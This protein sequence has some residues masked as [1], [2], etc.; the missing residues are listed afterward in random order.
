MVDVLIVGC[1]IVGASVAY[2][3]AKD[4]NLRVMLVDKENDV[5]TGTTRANSAILHAGY[6]PVPG[7]LMAK[8]NVR[9]SVLAKQLCEKLDVPYRQVGSLVTALEKEQLPILQSLYERGEKNGVP[10]LELLDGQAA[11]TIEPQLS[12]SVK[13]ALYAPTA[14][15]VCPWEMC[16]ALCETAVKNGTELKLGQEVT[17]ISRWKDGTFRVT[18]GGEDITARFVI[19][20]AGVYSDAVHDMAAPHQFSILPNKGEYYLFDKCE[21]GRVGHVIFQCPTAAGKGVLV[22]PTVDGNLLAGPDA[23]PVQ[24][25]NDVSTSAGGLAF[26]RDTAIKSVPG[27]VFKN[28]IRNFA[29]VRAAADTDDFVIGEAVPGFFDA[30]A[31]KSPGLTSAP[32]IGEYLVELLVKAGLSYAPSADAVDTRKRI[33]FRMLPIEEKAALVAANPAYG[34]VVCRCET[35]TEGEILDALHSPI[36]P[37]SVDGVKR[38]CG[39]GMGRCQGGFCGPA[40]QRLIADTLG[41]PLEAVPQDR[42][43]SRL[44]YGETKKGVADSED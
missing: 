34:R 25:G 11:R 28:S 24:D 5:A 16:L 36:P 43:G 2:E 10:G 27:L 42:K 12:P 33:R 39:A 44:V 14:A 40:V 21:G 32:A 38:R 35:V 23:Q 31:I 19:N 1:G 37:V 29:G 17:A 30:A 26:V 22:A 6:D 18:A 7:T 3:L 8:L 9:G 20:A 13:G 15:I 41:L 4:K